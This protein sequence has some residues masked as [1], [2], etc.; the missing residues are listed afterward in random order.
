V[1]SCAKTVVSADL[2]EGFERAGGNPLFALEFVRMLVEA[3]ARGGG[4]R[5]SAP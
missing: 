5:P 3:A 1:R 4:R 2:G